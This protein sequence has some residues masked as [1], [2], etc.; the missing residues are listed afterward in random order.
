M[1]RQAES[2][3]LLEKAL[4]GARLLYAYTM[5]V[6]VPIEIV[7]TYT[8]DPDYW[9][10]DFDGDPLPNLALTWEG[11]RLQPGSVMALSAMRK[12]GTPTPAGSIRMKLLYYER[13]VEISFLYL[14]GSYLIYRFVYEAA[15]PTRT[16][17]TVNALIHPGGPS[18]NTLRQRMY[19]RRRRKA[20]IVDHLRVKRELESRVGN[21]EDSTPKLFL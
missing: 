19:A 3:T 21:L 8:G 16:E 20:A 7:F 1:V 15:S 17:F 12:D 14:T 6:E 5:Y 11:P 18:M 10:R 13:N 4:D 2:T 9:S